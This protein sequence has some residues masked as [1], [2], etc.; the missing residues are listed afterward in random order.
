MDPPDPFIVKVLEPPTRVPL[1]IQLPVT[2][3]AKVEA[4]NVVEAPIVILPVIKM[5]DNAV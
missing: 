5:F 1:L 2:W 3:C 4:L